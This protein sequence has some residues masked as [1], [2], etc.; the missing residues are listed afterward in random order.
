MTQKKRQNNKYGLSKA[1]QKTTTAF[2]MLSAEN[3]SLKKSLKKT[4]D[5][6]EKMRREKFEHEKKNSLL[7]YRLEA[8]FWIELFKFLASAGIGVSASYFIVGNLY[9]SLTIGIPTVV[10]FIVTLIFGKK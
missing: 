9:L 2:K 7:E 1:E 6:L 8:T 3:D 5:E 10:I 4:Q